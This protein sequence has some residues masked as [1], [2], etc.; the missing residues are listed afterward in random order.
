MRAASLNFLPFEG[1]NVARETD[2]HEEPC[3]GLREVLPVWWEQTHTFVSFEPAPDETQRHRV[4]FSKIYNP[5]FALIIGQLAFVQHMIGRIAAF[6]CI[7]HRV[8]FAEL[9]H[10]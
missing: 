7:F 4:Y 3:E 2:P 6:S 8:I 5:K 9:R 1:R 10:L